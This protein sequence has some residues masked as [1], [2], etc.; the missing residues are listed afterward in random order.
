MVNNAHQG[1]EHHGIG[2]MIAQATT[3]NNLHNLPGGMLPALILPLDIALNK[4]MHLLWLERINDRTGRTPLIHQ[5]DKIMLLAKIDLSTCHDQAIATILH[6]P[7][8]FLTN[9]GE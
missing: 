4:L 3:I 1:K 8:Q 6:Q 9:M 7:R 5:L 2:T